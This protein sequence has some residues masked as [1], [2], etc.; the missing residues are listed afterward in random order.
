MANEIKLTYASGKSNITA[1]VFSADGETA[2]GADIALSDTGHAGLYLGDLTTIKLGDVIVFFEGS[3]YLTGQTYEAIDWVT[4]SSSD[5]DVLNITL[6]ND[7]LGLIGASPISAEGTTEEN[8]I[9]CERYYADARN[10]ILTAHRWNFAK[11]RAYAIQTTNPLFG[12]DNAFTP[13]SDYLKILQIEGEPDSVF[14]VENA[15]IVTNDGTTPSVW[16]TSTDYLAGEYIQSDDSGSTLTYLVDT[17]FTST[18]SSETT[19]LSSYCT[20]KSA[21]LDVLKVEYI[22]EVTDIDKWPSYA[23]QCFII[24]LARMLS[25]PIKQNEEAALNLQAMLYGSKNVV[26]YLNTARS[27]DAQ[28]GGAIAMKTNTWISARL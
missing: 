13:P 23:K 17:G 12:Y 18:A 9:L 2:R 24:N 26:G 3:L 15:L 7:A 20:S 16:A 8:Y 21:D 19:D 1:D 10:E 28:E 6:C 14:E 5:S 4:V 22:W 25:S 27:I 11:K